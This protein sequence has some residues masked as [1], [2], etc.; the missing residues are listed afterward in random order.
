MPR[1]NTV[2]EQTEGPPGKQTRDPGIRNKEIQNKND[3]PTIW[4]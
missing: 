4:G 2:F 1:I 3:I